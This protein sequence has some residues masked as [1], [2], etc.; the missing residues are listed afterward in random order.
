LGVSSIGKRLLAG[1]GCLKSDLIVQ[2]AHRPA[3][4]AD[5]HRDDEYGWRTSVNC[6]ER[7]CQ[8]AAE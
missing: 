7:A 2:T 6:G 5:W 3:W 4:S 8:S 1:I